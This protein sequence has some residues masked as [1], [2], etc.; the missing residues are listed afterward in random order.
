MESA[1]LVHALTKKVLY[2]MALS[3]KLSKQ[4]VIANGRQ[5]QVL[6]LVDLYSNKFLLRNKWLLGKVI[7][8]KC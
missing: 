4:R 5:P 3:P 2:H 8:S 1:A 6:T 7:H